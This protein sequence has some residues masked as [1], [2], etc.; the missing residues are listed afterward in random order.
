[1]QS[2]TVST[3]GEFFP[4][5]STSRLG[6]RFPLGVVLDGSPRAFPVEVVPEDGANWSLIQVLEE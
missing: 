3:S 5:V 4:S 1:M 2:L 6:G